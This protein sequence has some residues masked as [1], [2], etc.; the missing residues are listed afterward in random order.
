MA[1][2]AVLTPWNDPISTAS[3]VP[4]ATACAVSPASS[5]VTPAIAPGPSA[6][7]A[8]A[9]NARRP[10]NRSIWLLVLVAT[11]PRDRLRRSRT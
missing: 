9:A 3:P 6:I 7:A 5:G 2:T 4:P 11:G 1:V 10:E 8:C